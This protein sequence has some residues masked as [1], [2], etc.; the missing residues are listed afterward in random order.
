MWLCA[1]GWR[2]WNSNHCLQ[3]LIDKNDDTWARVK[4]RVSLQAAWPSNLLKHPLLCTGQDKG[5]AA[6]SRSFGSPEKVTRRNLKEPTLWYGM[7][8]KR[9]VFQQSWVVAAHP[10]RTVTS[11]ATSLH[12]YCKW[13]RPEPS[14]HQNSLQNSVEVRSSALY[15]QL[16]NWKPLTRHLSNSM[17]PATN[18]ALFPWIM[19]K[20]IISVARYTT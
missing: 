10:S 9:H 15:W 12:F 8:N 5:P 18:E 17:W 13:Y 1:E 7:R 16:L 3:Y 19:N 4:N 11:A 2:G 6:Q 14:Q 20:N